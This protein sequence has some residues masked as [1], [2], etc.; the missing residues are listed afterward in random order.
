ML[1]IY[2]ELNIKLTYQCYE[3]RK[4]LLSYICDGGLVINIFANFVN[5]AIIL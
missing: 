2:R 4:L 5:R 3:G 1:L